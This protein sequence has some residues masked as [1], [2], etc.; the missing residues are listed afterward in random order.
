MQHEGCD[1]LLFER[2][3]GLYCLDASIPTMLVH[4]T[5]QENKLKY[6]KR[7]VKKAEEAAQVRRRLFFPSD[8]A[9]PKLSSINNIPVTR[10]DVIRSIDIFGRDKNAIRGKLTDTKTKTIPLEP[11]WKHNDQPQFLSVDLFFIDGDGYMISVMSPLDHTAVVHIKNRTTAVLRGALLKILA[12]IDQQ[13]YEVSYILTDNE[14][15]MAALFVELEQAGYGINPAGAGDH[16]PIVERKIRTVKERV[17]AYLQSI[18]YT[19]MFSL[20]RY[21]VEFCV[22]S[23]NLLPDDQR[24]DSTSP[25]EAFTGMK[26]DYAKQ[27][28]MSFGDYAECK[29]PNR[30]PAN[31]PK[32]RTDPCIALL[33]ML[34]Q[35]GSY[36]FFDLGTRRTVIRTKWIELPFSDEIIARRNHLASNQ[37]RKLRV[38][39]FFSR[40]EPRDEDDDSIAEIS[41]HEL[42][43]HNNS[44]PTS[45]S[46]NGTSDASD[47]ETSDN[48]KPDSTVQDDQNVADPTHLDESDRTRMLD[49]ENPAGPYETVEPNNLYAEQP[50]VTEP[51]HSY[52]TR[53][54]GDAPINGPYKEGER[55]VNAMLTTKQKYKFGVF[56]NMTIREAI[57]QFGDSAKQAVINELQQ[58]IRLQVFKF[59]IPNLLSAEQRKSRIPSK[60]FVKPKY[61]PNGL[62]NKIK[63]RL[64]GGG[65]RQKRYLYT[66]NDTS[67]PT[68]S[69]VGLFIIAT[70][71]AREHRHVITMDIGGAYLR[72]YMKK[73]VLVLINK[74]ESDILVELYPELAEYRDESGRLTAE[75]LK[76]LYGCIE[77][78]KLWYDTLSSKLLANGYIQNP[79][80]QCIFNKIHMQ[81]GVQ[82]TIGIHVD[83]C[84]ISCVIPA[85]LE[86]IVEWFAEA[87]ED[88]NVTRGSVHQFTGMTLDYTQHDKLIV[89]MKNQIDN[90]MERTGSKS[91]AVTPSESDLFVVDTTS[92]KLDRKRDEEFHSIVATISYIAKRIKPECLVAT[93]MLA[94]RVQ[95]PTEQD[96]RKLERLLAYINNTREIPLCLEMDI[97]YPVR[98]IASIDSSHATHG[99]YRGHTGVY[100]SL[101][102]GCIQAI[103]VKQTIN[104]KSS[105]ET[106]LVAASDGEHL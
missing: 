29:N 87:F 81:E 48:T 40:S 89:T 97:S 5:V 82:S 106:E 60:T 25:Y 16:V 73:Q 28:R 32:P 100:I 67:S 69:L 96:W 51:I 84:F 10:Q 77:S 98:I 78:G 46:E 54:R 75:A 50:I 63:A 72:A 61:F 2:V 9:I 27:L 74:E 94:S 53:S 49:M 21:L 58:L 93:S 52:N 20:L 68:I 44:V 66:E 18:P 33:P 64:V 24:E 19:L 56:S 80:D 76:A 71:A 4:N 26:V 1:T 92:P 42:F 70:I 14:G 90:L 35:Q 3:G 105:A 31:G 85:I 88:L 41:D 55:W 102:K 47:T 86:S 30:K 12:K 83:D 104:T 17:R 15:G 59:H 36:L 45:D 11:V 8:E 37:G 57:E 38:L 7:Q 6:T 95:D 22:I 99:D 39:P 34:N 23:I 79:Y 65:H 91:K 13:H 101:G 43:D 103:S 62:F